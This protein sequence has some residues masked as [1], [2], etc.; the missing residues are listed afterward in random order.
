MGNLTS[1]ILSYGKQTIPVTPP[2]QPLISIKVNWPLLYKRFSQWEPDWMMICII[3]YELHFIYICA[4]LRV[5]TNA[6]FTPDMAS[7]NPNLQS[8]EKGG[9][10][11]VEMEDRERESK[12]E[13]DQ[14]PEV[15]EVK[16]LEGEDKVEVVAIKKEE[17]V[18][19]DSG[20]VEEMPEVKK[21]GE[22]LRPGPIFPVSYQIYQASSANF[23]AL[24]A[25]TIF[26]THRHWSHN[27]LRKR[28]D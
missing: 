3:L 22:V 24:T 8:S 6:S 25:W 28:K 17:L 27:K 7:P 23:L 10:Q 15:K 9:V 16:K 14:Q 2:D 12:V 20:E 26:K 11:Q 1:Q 13:E 18:V 4:V 21:F 19:E 5:Q